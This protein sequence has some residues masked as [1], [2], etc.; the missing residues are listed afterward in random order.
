MSV[1]YVSFM[2]QFSHLQSF[3]SFHF[4][5]NNI[6]PDP[7][8]LVGGSIPPANPTPFKN[9]PNQDRSSGVSRLYQTSIGRVYRRN[10]ICRPHLPVYLSRDRSLFSSVPISHYH[11]NIESI[12][13]FSKWDSFLLKS[14]S[15]SFLFRISPPIRHCKMGAIS[16]PPPSITNARRLPRRRRRKAAGGV[17]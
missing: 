3:S 8:K 7:R 14:F 6:F 9:A 5:R 2:I 13:H 4:F 16:Q 10:W 15:S 11:K 12:F 17:V 1:I